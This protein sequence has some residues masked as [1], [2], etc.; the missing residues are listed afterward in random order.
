MLKIN[1]ENFPDKAFREYISNTFDQNKK[2]FLSSN[3]LNRVKKIDVAKNKKIINLR[4]IEYFQ[5]LIRL[6]CWG[7]GIKELDVSKNTALRELVCFDTGITK[8]YLKNNVALRY[9]DCHNTGITKLN[10]SN[11]PKLEYVNCYGTEITKINVSVD[12]LQLE[13]YSHK[14]INLIK[15]NDSIQD[16]IKQAKDILLNKQNNSDYYTQAFIDVSK[17]LYN[18]GGAHASGGWANG[19]DTAV[20]NMYDK[21]EKFLYKN[22][23][24]NIELYEEVMDCY[25]NNGEESIEKIDLVSKMKIPAYR[26]GIKDILEIMKDIDVTMP[27]DENSQE[28]GKGYREVLDETK[29]FLM[30]SLQGSSIQDK[31]SQA[32]ELLDNKKDVEKEVKAKEMER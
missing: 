25:G 14:D 17:H 29:S 18:I 7:T 4:G 2:G 3:E 22:S 5:K 9:L 28:F 31:I 20:D 24:V 8:L 30:E 19:Y 1:E 16:K 15:D 32:K 12:S 27:L 21:I 11:N 23:K 10:V 26:E 13:I 6:V